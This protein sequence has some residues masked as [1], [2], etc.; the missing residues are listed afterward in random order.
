ML[1]LHLVTIK[2]KN[3]TAQSI[4]QD[5]G[6]LF[7]KIKESLPDIFKYTVIDGVISQLSCC[8]CR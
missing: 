2:H 7:T 8:T 1:K 4:Q 5:I 3:P 6:T